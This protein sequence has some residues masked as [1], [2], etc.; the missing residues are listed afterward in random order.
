M[1]DRDP[2]GANLCEPRHNQLKNRFVECLSA[3]AFPL[4]LRRVSKRDASEKGGL[5]PIFSL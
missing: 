5:I 4:M 2:W 1:S 3:L